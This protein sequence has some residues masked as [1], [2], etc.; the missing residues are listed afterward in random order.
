MAAEF[1]G[2]AVRMRRENEKRLRKV[3]G[4]NFDAWNAGER[5]AF[6]DYAVTLSLTPDVIRWKRADKDGLTQII[7]AKAGPDETKY[8]R[9]MQKHH[10]LREAFLHCGS[11]PVSRA[12]K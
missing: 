5:K 10:T 12:G 7:R 11:A 9:L 3:L 1:G 4:V 8:L 2:S 6:S